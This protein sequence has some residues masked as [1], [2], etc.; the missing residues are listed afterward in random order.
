MSYTKEV[1]KALYDKLGALGLTLIMFSLAS[2]ILFAM[3]SDLLAI[4]CLLYIF[5]ILTRLPCVYS[6]AIKDVECV[7]SSAFLLTI[8]AGPWLAA[9]YGFTCMWLSNFV[10][11]WGQGEDKQYLLMESIAIPFAVAFTPWILRATNFQIITGVFWFYIARFIM[12]FFLS[13]ILKKATLPTTSFLNVVG[14]F[15]AITQA[16][17]VVRLIGPSL[18]GMFGVSGF[19]LGTFPVFRPRGS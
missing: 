17:I 18:L 15:I 7:S 10:A 13:F 6:D 1:L 11:P 8:I 14:F 2:A 4:L 5:G 19:S 3:G 12:I 16:Y 9:F